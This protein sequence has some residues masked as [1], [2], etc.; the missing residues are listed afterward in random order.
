MDSN[1]LDNNIPEQQSVYWCYHC[2]EEVRSNRAEGADLSCPA[3][4]NGFLEEIESAAEDVSDGADDGADDVSQSLLDEF[5]FGLQMLNDL[6]AE[7]LAHVLSSLDASNPAD[8]A[9]R[10]H[11]VQQL[12]RRQR[13]RDEGTLQDEASGASDEHSGLGG[14]HEQAQGRGGSEI[15]AGAGGSRARALPRDPAADQGGNGSQSDEDENCEDEWEE[16]GEGEEEQGESSADDIP[17]GL[18][19]GQAAE[20]GEA[21][22]GREG[23][24]PSEPRGRGRQR[25]PSGAAVPYDRHAPERLAA[26]LSVQSEALDE[27]EASIGGGGG[28]GGEGGF[29]FG[30][31][32]G[33]VYIGNPGDYLDAQGFDALLNDLAVNDNS[34][35]GAPPASRAAVEG[36]PSVAVAEA[37]VESG[38]SQC[39][40]CKDAGAAG[41]CMLRL[42][43]SHLYHAECIRPWLAARNSCPLCRFELPTDDADYEEQRR[44][45]AA[46]APVAAAAARRGRAIDAAVAGAGAAAAAAGE[47]AGGAAAGPG[48]PGGGVSEEAAGWGGNGL[49]SG[50]GAGAGVG[51]EAGEGELGHCAAGVGLVLGALLNVG[52]MALAAYMGVKLLTG[53]GQER[54]QPGGGAA[55]AGHRAG[56]SGGGGGGSVAGVV[57]VAVAARGGGT[58]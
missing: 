39:S 31:N 13:Q 40:V 46:A 42:P 35:Q 25:A 4:N 22:G 55:G 14:S 5:R 23:D 17:N 32:V 30:R 38:H 58:A 37:E 43:C 47:G 20:E 10:M 29:G 50:A 3:C 53:G 41:D 16:V 36:L 54:A 18:D 49:G 28:G 19:E 45:R 48:S 33:G 51:W 24:A 8:S 6:D 57:V 21:G 15:L 1:H 26:L 7:Q 12:A 34:V 11:V 44:H 56:G 52:G 2:D 9:Y 27:A